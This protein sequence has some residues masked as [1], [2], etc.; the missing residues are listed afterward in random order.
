MMLRW[1]VRYNESTKR[2]GRAHSEQPLGR[3]VVYPEESSV[4][5]TN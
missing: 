2:A 5:Y 1:M 3:P 4:K